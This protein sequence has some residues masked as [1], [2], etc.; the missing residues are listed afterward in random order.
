VKYIVLTALAV[1]LAGAAFMAH[2]QSPDANELEQ[3]I[4]AVKSSNQAFFDD[5][6]ALIAKHPQSAKNFR[7][8]NMSVRPGS[9]GANPQPRRVEE[10]CAVCL[11]GASV[12]LPCPDSIL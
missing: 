2:G 6:D 4:A 7:V 1:I 3:R 10:H 11:S 9:D 12:C 8:L 5:L